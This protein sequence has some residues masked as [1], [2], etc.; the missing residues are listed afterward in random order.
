MPK[1]E[2][3]PG[4]VRISINQGVNMDYYDKHPLEF[5]NVKAAK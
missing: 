2:K 3:R 1:K 4:M 5:C